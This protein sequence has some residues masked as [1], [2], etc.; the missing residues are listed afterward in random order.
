MCLFIILS[1]FHLFNNK[2][3]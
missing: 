3:A 1:T 2:V